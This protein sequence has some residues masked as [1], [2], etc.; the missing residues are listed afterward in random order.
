MIDILIISVFIILPNETKLYC[1]LTDPEL[2]SPDDPGA[3]IN[4]EMI[5]G[6]VCNVRIDEISYD[7]YGIPHAKIKLVDILF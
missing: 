2:F 1:I 3:L 7:A 5:N 6:T 4:Q